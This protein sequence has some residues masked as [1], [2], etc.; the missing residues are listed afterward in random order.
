M[1]IPSLSQ[2]LIATNLLRGDAVDPIHVLVS[3]TSTL[4]AGSILIWIATRLYQREKL[5]G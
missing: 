4:A 5:L 2:H 1:M 3:I